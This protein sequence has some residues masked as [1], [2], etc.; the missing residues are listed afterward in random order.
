MYLIIT[1]FSPAT[2]ALR[3]YLQFV[4]VKVAHQSKKQVILCFCIDICILPDITQR[5]VLIP[6]RRLG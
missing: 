2:S 3:T 4:R 1:Y 5:K 6:F